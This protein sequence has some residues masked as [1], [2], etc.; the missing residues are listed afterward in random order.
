MK[1]PPPQAVE[2]YVVGLDPVRKNELY[3]IPFGSHLIL[4]AGQH[5]CLEAGHAAKSLECIYHLG[6]VLH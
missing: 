5:S 6:A 4:E 1:G 3:S 2:R